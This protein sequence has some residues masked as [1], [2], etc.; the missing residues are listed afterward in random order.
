MYKILE[1][2]SSC[3]LGWSTISA[4]PD[5][6]DSTVSYGICWHLHSHRNR[7]LTYVHIIE[8]FISKIMNKNQYQVY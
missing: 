4:V 3:H 7:T 8:T 5:T 2:G 6:R 1:R